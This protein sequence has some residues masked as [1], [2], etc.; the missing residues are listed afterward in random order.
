MRSLVPFGLLY[1]VAC[2]SD[3]SLTVQNPAP[4]AD[5]ISHDD[6]SEILEGFSI[7][8]TGLVSDSNHTP[9]Q[10]TTTWV[11]NGETVC[12]NVIPDEGGG[13]SCDV[14]FTTDDTDITLQVKDAE[15]KGGSDSITVEILETEEPVAE[16]ITPEST[17]VYYSDQKIAFEAE[18]A[19]QHPIVTVLIPLVGT[20]FVSLS[21]KSH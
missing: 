6:G 1:L 11:V 12:E 20:A 14:V 18:I 4:T 10:L 17:G 21:R 5:I 9:D 16:I 7:T 3:K 8:L 15:N 19:K 13:T 2:E